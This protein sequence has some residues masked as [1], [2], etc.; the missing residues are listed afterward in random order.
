MQVRRSQRRWLKRCI[1]VTAPAREVAVERDQ[2][3]MAGDQ[4]QRRPEHA[5]G[6]AA[7]AVANGYPFAPDGSTE[8][9][10]AQTAIWAAGV[11]AS[12]LACTPCRLG[13]RSIAG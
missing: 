6:V 2:P 13:K 7:G 8:R 5:D 11:K 4:G 1:F 3:A 9:I 10:P 12:T